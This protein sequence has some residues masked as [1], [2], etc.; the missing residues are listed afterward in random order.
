MSKDELMDVY[1]RIKNV[2]QVRMIRLVVLRKGEKGGLVGLKEKK[3]KNNMDGEIKD[4]A[5]LKLRVEKK[6]GAELEML[7]Q[8]DGRPEKKGVT[9]KSG[10]KIVLNEEPPKNKRRS[11]KYE[12][13]DEEWTPWMKKKKIQSRQK[14]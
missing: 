3:G 2:K 9:G 7:Q 12:D 10:K 1:G 8:K 5:E 13:E 14:L 6:S 4:Q 11:K